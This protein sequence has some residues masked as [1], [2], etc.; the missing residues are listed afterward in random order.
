MTKPTT[1]LILLITS[2]LFIPNCY[3][4]TRYVNTAS[5]A[6]GDGTTNATSGANRAYASLSDWEDAEDDSALT[7][8][9]TVYCEG[10][11]ADTTAVII[12]GWTGNSATNYI[13]ITTT[14]ANR[15]NGKWDDSKYSLEINGIAITIHEEN[16]RI[17]GLQIDAAPT[18]TGN[19]RKGIMASSN[20]TT[21]INIYLSKNIIKKSNVGSGSSC[22]GIQMPIT[23]TNNVFYIW[24]N[25]IY[26]ISEFEGRGIGCNGISN[27]YLYNNTI[28]NSYYGIWRSNGTALAKNN[29]TQSCTDGFSG[30]FDS[31]SDYN[32]SDV[33]QAD[34]DSANDTF[35]GYKTV[36]FADEANDD[37]RLSPNDTS[38]RNHG[39]DLSNDANLSFSDDIQGQS[40]SAAA[41]GGAWDI[42]ADEQVS[43]GIII[44]GWD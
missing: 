7:E 34:A 3:A 18:T 25:I 37:F 5:T 23:G 4:L 40:R 38:A 33:S 27:F 42:G 8:P 31:S 22:Y 11:A 15:H 41:A 44:G 26:N 43:V 17:E 32:I 30:T 1:I 24:D 21:N 28:Y 14:Q 39:T 6:G 16:T 9:M 13:K 12:A 10:T 20:M 2:L 36:T 29:I 35:N 19:N